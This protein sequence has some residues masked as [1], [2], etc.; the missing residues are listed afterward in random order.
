MAMSA[1]SR[2][3]LDLVS[4][5]Q[6]RYFVS[7]M[8]AHSF[9]AA[10]RDASISQAALSEQIALLE[11]TL[12]V[13]LFDRASGRAVATASGHELDRRVSA[14]LSELQAALRDVQARASTVAGLVRI[15]LVQSYAGCWVLPVVRRAQAQWPQLAIALRRRTAQ[16]LVEGVLRGDFDLAVSF[17]PEPHADLEILACFDE[18]VVAVG[19]KPRRRRRLLELSEVANHP[20]ALL[21]SEYAMRRQ[22]DNGYRGTDHDLIRATTRADGSL[23]IVWEDRSGNDGSSYG[24]YARLVAANNTLGGTLAQGFVDL[25]NRNGLTSFVS[26][27]ALTL[28][29]RSEAGDGNTLA[30]PR[31]RVKNREKAKIHIGDKLPVFTT[32]STANVG[33]SASVSYLDVGLKLEIE[34]QVQLDN[35]VTIKVALE[36]SS[37]TREITGP[38]G[39][40]AYQVGTRQASTTLRLRDGETQILAGLINDRDI[41]NSAG[42]PV[43]H[44][45]PVAGRL[46]GSRNDSVERTEIVLLVT[47]RIVRNLV[48]PPVAAG[49]LP[50]GTEAQP[51]ARPM[52]LSS[53]AAGLAPGRGGAAARFSPRAAPSPA[54]AEAPGDGALV[55][56]SGP[57]QVMAGNL[58]Q[59]TVR[60]NGSD[61]LDTG[62]L[63]DTAVFDTPAAGGG[64]RVPVQV[65]P[66]GVQSIML[67][68]KP[69]APAMDSALALEDGSAMWRV[70]IQASEPAQSA[71]PDA[72]PEANPPA[73]PA[74]EPAASEGR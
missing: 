49:L 22:L 73:D 53:G 45:M 13:Q 72:N 74:A 10:S 21:P 28:N 51:G 30:N 27:P 12:D 36:V 23:V 57:E 67:K 42:L 50:S 63:M 32:T 46:F 6:L 16:A 3:P 60:N 54:A 5:R 4:L 26:N 44:D 61:P 7:A 11:S 8:R 68:V 18:P 29:L 24:V 56:L 48:Q 41:R 33:V 2:D 70:R 55:S 66:R 9:S 14:C 34:P 52:A 43:L 47:P 20:L 1:R 38:Q 37:I 58:L 71:D 31:I 65:P 59:I 19:L 64:A 17:D 40:I 25:R 69:D 62:L 35:D 15:G 39:S